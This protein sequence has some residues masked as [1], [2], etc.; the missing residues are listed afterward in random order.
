VVLLLTVTASTVYA[1]ALIPSQAG[2]RPSIIGSAVV[3]WALAASILAASLRRSHASVWSI[4][5][6]L[7]LAFVA[8]LSSSAWATGSVIMSGEGPFDTPY[9]SALV[10]EITQVIP[11]RQ[12]AL[13]WAELARFVGF[14]PRSQA[15]DVFETSYLASYDIFATGREFFPVG[16]YSGQVPAPSLHQFMGDVT[17]GKIVHATAAVAPRSHNPVMIRIITHCVRQTGRSA[18]YS[19][20][21]TTM[22]RFTCSRSDISASA[23]R[24]RSR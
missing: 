3:L 11:N 19:Y 17:A 14:V 5:C 10:T 24:H 22:R 4:S 15:A 6:G 7:M 13:S 2:I 21:G 20:Q 1:V 8:L 12:R 9:Q 18:T 16:G 23:H